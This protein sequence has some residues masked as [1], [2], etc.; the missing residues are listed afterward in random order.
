MSFLAFLVVITESLITVPSAHWTAIALKTPLNSATVHG[1]FEVVSGGTQIQAMILSRE[2]AER[3]NRGRS[4]RP[5]FTSGFEKSEQFRVLIPDAGDYVLILDNRLEARFPTQVS[6]RLEMTH[7]NDARAQTVP[8]ERRRATVALSL[9]FFGS[10][11][12]FSAVRFLRT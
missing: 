2:E 5:L 4:N 8:P 7:P 9:L 6:L 12:V 10:V 3:F 11:V 1:S